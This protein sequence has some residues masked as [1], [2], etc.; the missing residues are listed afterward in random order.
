MQNGNS[1]EKF[2]TLLER[3]KIRKVILPNTS[4]DYTISQEAKDLQK[5]KRF[6]N[7]LRMMILKNVR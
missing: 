5:Y 2:I 1:A 6:C 7:L 3:G 4:T